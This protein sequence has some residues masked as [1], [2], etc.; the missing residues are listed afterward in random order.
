MATVNAAKNWKY[1][2]FVVLLKILIKTFSFINYNWKDAFTNIVQVFLFLIVTQ[3][4]LSRGRDLIKP[5]RGSF[6]Q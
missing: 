2:V 6:S 1:Q 5:Q 3:T 4:I